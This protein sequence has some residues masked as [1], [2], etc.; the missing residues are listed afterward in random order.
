MFARLHIAFSLNDFVYNT[1]TQITF[2]VLGS[3]YI[4]LTIEIAFLSLK[5]ASFEFLGYGNFYVD[6]FTYDK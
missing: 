2:F 6:G 5:C 3:R 1:Y 4:L